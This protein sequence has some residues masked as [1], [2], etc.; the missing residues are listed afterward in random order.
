M[1]IIDFGINLVFNDPNVFTSIIILQKESEETLRK[2]TMVE[3][4]DILGD[5][6]LN[7]KNFKIIIKKQSELKDH[8]KPLGPIAE[9]ILKIEPKLGDIALVKDIGLN[10]W[11]KGRGK[12]RGDSIGSR[13][14]YEGGKKHDK[15]I[16]YLKG[17]NISRYFSQFENNWLKHDYEAYLDPESDIFRFSPEF[18]ERNEKIIYRQTSDKIIATLDNQ[19]FYLDKTVHLIVLTEEYGNK[20]SLKYILAIL[21]SKLASYFYQDIAK[22]TGRTFAQVMTFNMKKIPIYPLDISNPSSKAI[23]DDFE[24]LVNRMFDLNMKMNCINADFYHYL[25][26]RPHTTAV[27]RNFMDALPVNDKEVLKDHFGKPVSTI[28]VE[29]F[30]DFEVLEEGEWLVFKVGYLYKGGKGKM[31][32]SSNVRAL[33][34]RIPDISMRKFIFYSL[35]NTTPGKL[36]SGNILE[37]LHK[38][39]IPR[40]VT[41]G[42][43]NRRAIGELM[44][45]FLAEAAKKEAVEREIRETDAAIDKKVYALYGLTDDE[46]RI[47]EESTKQ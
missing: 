13:V 30:E 1:K 9:K 39:K 41:N 20:F 22:E 19:K 33:R 32:S 45:P 47:I 18:L 26:L 15:D 34:F 7:D 6:R 46:I 28:D 14:L 4:I 43:D 44:A 2:E 21:N 3:H 17:R 29:K 10:Y 11:T 42:E 23:I 36:G 31:L 24:S 35:K 27:L 38:I 16:P 12:K 40:L 5:G 25:N 37:Q 8:W